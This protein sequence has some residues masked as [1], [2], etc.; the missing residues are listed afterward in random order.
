MKAMVLNPPAFAFIVGTRAALAAGLGLLLSQKLPD[1]RR[2]ALGTTLVAIGAIT[3]LPAVFSVLRG[4]RRGA[5]TDA[6]GRD[7]RL[8]GVTRFPRKGDDDDLM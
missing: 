2:R 5:Q 6:V 3:T 7:E 8:R 1:A 4:F